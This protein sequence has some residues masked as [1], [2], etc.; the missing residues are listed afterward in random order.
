MSQLL[1]LLLLQCSLLTKCT[2]LLGSGPVTYW[3]RKKEVL[4]CSSRGE[5][6]KRQ[7]EGERGRG[8]EGLR[9]TTTTS[10]TIPLCSIFFWRYVSCVSVNEREKGGLPECRLR[11]GSPIERR[12]SSLFL[13]EHPLPLFLFL[14]KRKHFE[15]SSYIYAKRK[16]G[17]SLFLYSSLFSPFFLPLSIPFLPSTY[18]CI[19]GSIQPVLASKLT[20]A[21]FFSFSSGYD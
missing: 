6:N 20:H 19:G 10:T 3:W 18:L 15:S 5:K 11:R 13:F 9:V 12:N 14:L 1:L 16:K 21:C 7:K 8:R 4:K 2:I 17:Y